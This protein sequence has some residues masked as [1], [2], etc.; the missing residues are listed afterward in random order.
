MNSNNNSKKD[1]LS[2]LTSEEMSECL[3]SILTTVKVRKNINET[4]L[5]KVGDK[6]VRVD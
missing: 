6:Y 1:K 3:S 4:T 2:G 5:E